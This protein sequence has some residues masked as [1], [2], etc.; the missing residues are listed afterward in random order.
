MLCRE[1]IYEVLFKEQCREISTRNSEKPR[2]NFWKFTSNKSLDENY[3]KYNNTFAKM[4]EL[5]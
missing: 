3:C 4:P 1:K 2:F 5:T